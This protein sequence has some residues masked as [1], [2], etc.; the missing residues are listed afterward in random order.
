M[1]R[2]VH[3]GLLFV[4]GFI[5]LFLFAGHGLGEAGTFKIV[6]TKGSKAFSPQSVNVSVGEKITWVNQD[7]EDHFLTSAGPLFQGV[8]GE[9]E[10]LEIHQLLHPGDRFHHSFKEPSTY[11]YFCAIHMEMWGTVIVRE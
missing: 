2:K 10:S 6:I 8:T 5:F 4:T 11:Y 7:Q 9:T 3:R 1:K